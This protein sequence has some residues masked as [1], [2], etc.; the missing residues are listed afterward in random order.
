MEAFLMSKEPSI[1]SIL[2]EEEKKLKQEKASQKAEKLGKELAHKINKKL[3]TAKQ[4]AT[5]HNLIWNTTNFIKRNNKTIHSIIL[6][7][8]F[9]LSPNSK[10]RLST[11]EFKLPNGNSVIV[12]LHG[13]QTGN[14]KQIA[15]QKYKAL[16]KNLL[17]NSG[18]LD[19]QLYQA[20]LIRQAKIV[21]KDKQYENL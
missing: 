4:F 5:Q 12:I 19:Y 10:Q 15:S 17:Q 8:A 7:K 9:Q 14:I 3:I 16:K 13:I 20:G 11:S 21:Y 18:S 1:V 6:Y 2:K